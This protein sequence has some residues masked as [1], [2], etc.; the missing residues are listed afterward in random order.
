MTRFRASDAS[1]DPQGLSVTRRRI[2]LTAILSS[3]LFAL[4]LISSNAAAKNSIQVGD[5]SFSA[6]YNGGVVELPIMGT[7]ILRYGGIIKVYAAALYYPTDIKRAQLMNPS[8]PKRL[9]L[10]Y[11][12]GLDREQFIEAAEV[13]L[14]SQHGKSGLTALRS[15]L[16]KLHELFVDVESGDRYSITHLPG[17]GLMLE[18]ND[19]VAGIVPDISL[20]TAYFGIW[21]GEPPISPGLKKDLT[22]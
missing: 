13:T 1:P 21:L 5:A 11:F 9:E 16:D 17:K 8:V 22:Y 14:E 15:S 10:A 19:K 2:M 7:G 18:H 4:S 6:E 20:S 3:C 12:V